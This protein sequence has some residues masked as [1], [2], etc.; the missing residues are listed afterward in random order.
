[1]RKINY[2]LCQCVFFCQTISFI[3]FQKSIYS[4]NYIFFQNILQAC[5]WLLK[6][7]S[8]WIKLNVKYLKNW[9]QENMYI[10]MIIGK[11]ICIKTQQ[12][13]TNL[14]LNNKDLTIEPK[15]NINPQNPFFEQ[16]W[17]RLKG[18]IFGKKPNNK[19][20]QLCTLFL[21]VI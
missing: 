16:T 7:F 14:I 9:K 10:H 11:Y 2:N 6:L 17:K 18:S 19:G 13:A 3:S 5:N 8:T 12:E 4:M 15:T 20:S 1:M 21:N